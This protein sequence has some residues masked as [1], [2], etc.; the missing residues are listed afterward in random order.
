MRGDA[1]QAAEHFRRALQLADEADEIHP[2]DH[3]NYFI[4]L[5][6]VTEDPAAR[7]ATFAEARAR[8]VAAVGEEHIRTVRL[9]LE[10]ARHMAD[11]AEALAVLAPACEEARARLSHEYFGCYVCAS[12]VAARLEALGRAKE[13]AAALQDG[14]AVLRRSRAGAGPRIRRRQAAHRAGARSAAAGRAGAGARAAGPSARESAAPRRCSAH[15]RGAGGDRSPASAGGTAGLSGRAAG[16]RLVIGPG[17][18]HVPLVPDAFAT[19]PDLVSALREGKMIILVD[20]E[21]RENEGDIVVA[22]ELITSEQIVRMN[23]LASG[24]ITVPMPRDVAAPPAYRPDGAGE[25]GEHVHRV[26][27]HGRRVPQHQHGQ[28]RPRPG[29]HDPAPRRSARD[30]R[31]VRTAGPRQSANG[32]GRRRAQAGGTHR[33]VSRPDAAGGAPPGCGAVRDHGRRWRDAAAARAARARRVDG[34]PAGHDRRSDPLPAADRAAR[35]PHRQRTACAP[36]SASSTSTA[37]PAPSTPVG[38]P[39][40]SAATSIGTR[41]R[42]AACTARH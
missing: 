28:Q 37:T 36:P 6:L 17:L 13:A 40:S 20:D 42:C 11:P 41:R 32:A 3:A 19:V 25:R 27:G 29:A 15:R 22:A 35:H 16:I 21:D 30:R 33:G 8:L 23:R 31:R 34:L 10:R 18:W 12:D 38:T 2:V 5:A 7:D 9:D 14:G 4:N 24:I 1:E 39:P 26:H